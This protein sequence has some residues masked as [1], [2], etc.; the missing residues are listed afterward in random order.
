VAT[1]AD[2]QYWV[3][4]WIVVAVLLFIRHWRSG[5]GVGLLLTY[6]VSF[7]SIDWLASALLLLPGNPAGGLQFITDGMRLSAIAIV[8][9]GVAAEVVTLFWSR[10]Q[11]GAGADQSTPTPSRVDPAAVNLFLI[12]GLALHVVM[13]PI[14][15]FIPSVGAVVGT[16]SSLLVVGIGLKCWDAWHSGNRGRVWLWLAA[17][18]SLPLFTVVTMGFL[19]YGL[20]AL[21]MVFAFVGAFY[22]PRWLVLAI[23]VVVAYLGLSMYVT[24]MRDRNEIRAEV[25]V[26]AS[27][28][29]RMAT[30]RDTASQA[31]L[32][33]IY[34]QSH[35][36]RIEDRLDQNWL[37]GAA[38]AKLSSGA[39][40]FAYGSTIND[41]ALA[42]VPRVLWPEKTVA[43]GSGDLV[44][45]F[46]GLA[47][48]GETSVGIGQLMECYV[49][50]GETG[51]IV[52]F[53]IIG[54]LI[55]VVDRFAHEKLAAGDI[56][57]FLV[58]YMPGLNLLNVGGS[59]VDATSAAAAALVMAV[60]MR[61]IIAHLPG[62]TPRHDVSYAD[63]SIPQPE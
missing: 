15:R 46:T 1:T 22:Q 8:A 42:I 6:V 63:A 23:G 34:D 49:N 18:L 38:V 43:V 20:A 35:L 57:S 33:D 36:A 12:S 32:F 50:F 37:V 45:H 53:L 48:Q 31:E 28:S 30:I 17:T 56:G 21:V 9:T 47:F 4:V 2:L 62:P 61:I 13:A 51:V 11:V 52:G 3:I 27:L 58:W 7:G 54:A 41:A 16:G 39:V 60:L 55:T 24:Y 19:G 5:R 40:P 25:K 14:A 26:G 59:F 10:R 44:S 29:D